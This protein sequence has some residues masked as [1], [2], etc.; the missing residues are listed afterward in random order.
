[1]SGTSALGQSVLTL[2]ALLPEL[3]LILVS[4]GMMTAG[5]FVKRPR[6]IWAGMATV[7]LVVSLG[8]VVLI[9]PQGLSTYGAAVNLDALAIGMRILIILAGLMLIGMAHD[10]VDDGRASEFFGAILLVQAGAMI[11]T[12]ANDLVLLFVALELVSIPTY[13]LLYLPRRNASTLEAATKYF[14]LSVFSSGMLLFGLAYL[15]GMTGSSQIR[16]IAYLTHAAG[17]PWEHPAAGMGLV[18]GVFVM[19]G[20]G[21]RVAT[22]PFHFYAPD[23]YEGSPTVMAAL[24]SWVPKL[25]GFVALVR[26]LTAV[27][28]GSVTGPFESSQDMMSITQKLTWLG[29]VIGVATMTLGNTMAVIQRNLRRLLA[30]SSIAHAGY[31]MMGVTASFQDGPGDVG[32][33]L[34]VESILF[35]LVAYALMTLGFFAGIMALS[36]PDRPVEEVDDLCG[37][38]RSQPV[39][40]LG[41]TICLFSLAG[42][43]PLAGFWGKFQVFNAVVGQARDGNRSL[44]LALAILGGINA[45]IGAYYYLR[46]VVRMYLSEEPSRLEPR[47]AWPTALVAT[48]CI[49]GSVVIGIAPG[50]VAGWAR[51]AGRTAIALPAPAMAQA[52]VAEP[53]A[54][55]SGSGI[56]EVQAGE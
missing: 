55:K 10:Q 18:V 32:R 16:S 28:G 15:Y 7:A 23:V 12:A 4:I 40:A 48:A 30:Y 50:V 26:L 36:R 8:L 53:G 46:I 35:Y 2:T 27:F 17:S 52:S 19:A 24:L 5:A 33:V 1:M 56:H 42:I 9:Q 54:M 47:P 29:W 22:V 37:L 51:D 11:V 21:F 41:L 25:V 45:A 49:L 44:F 20:L 39:W 6:R 38:G 34:G 43:P 13:L 14:Y 31:L 3:I